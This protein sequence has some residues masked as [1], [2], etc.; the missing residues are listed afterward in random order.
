MKE[1]ELKEEYAPETI[2]FLSFPLKTMARSRESEEI[3]STD[4]KTKW[5]PPRSDFYPFERNF[6]KFKFFFEISKSGQLH[7]EVDKQINK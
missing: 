5:K 1:D 6:P 7:G 2:K 4:V 3:W